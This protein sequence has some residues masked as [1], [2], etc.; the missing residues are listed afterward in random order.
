MYFVGNSGD[1]YRYL[2]FDNDN[3]PEMYLNN[4][5]GTLVGVYCRSGVEWADKTTDNIFMCGGVLVESNASI[6]GVEAIVHDPYIS[7]SNESS[8]YKRYILNGTSASAS[9]VF[10]LNFANHLASI[11]PDDGAPSEYSSV[12]DVDLENVFESGEVY[13]TMSCISTSSMCSSGLQLVIHAN[14][15]DPVLISLSNLTADTGDYLLLY[16][17]NAYFTQSFRD[18]LCTPSRTGP[19][20]TGCLQVEGGTSLWKSVPDCNHSDAQNQW[21]DG[22]F[23]CHNSSSSEVVL[24]GLSED[25][26]VV[27]SDSMNPAKHIVLESDFIPDH[28]VTFSTVSVSNI[29]ETGAQ[30]SFN[31]SIPSWGCVYVTSGYSG[32]YFC[33]NTSYWS[34]NHEVSVSGLTTGRTYTYYA[35]SRYPVPACMGEVEGYGYPATSGGVTYVTLSNSSQGTFSTA[36]SAFKGN[37]SITIT[38]PSG[39]LI[40]GTNARVYAGFDSAYNDG[41]ET[42]P[43]IAVFLRG[44]DFY[45]KTFPLYNITYTYNYTAG[46]LYV[47]IGINR[48]SGGEYDILLYHNASAEAVQNSTNQSYVKYWNGT[49]WTLPSE[50]NP[51]NGAVT[52]SVDGYA[53]EALVN[54]SSGVELFIKNASRVRLNLYSYQVSPTVTWM[55]MGTRYLKNGTKRDFGILRDLGTNFTTTMHNFALPVTFQMDARALEYNTTAQQPSYTLA[56]GPFY[57][58]TPGTYSFYYQRGISP[59]LL[60]ALNPPVE[61]VYW[62]MNL[63]SYPAGASGATWVN[64]GTNPTVQSTWMQ[65]YYYYTNTTVLN[66]STLQIF[67][68]NGSAWTNITGNVD[69]NILYSNLTNFSVILTGGSIIS[70]NTT[71][72]YNPPSSGTSVTAVVSAPGYEITLTLALFT[73]AVLF[74]TVTNINR[75]RG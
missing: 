72:T 28:A 58:D 60:S 5:N 24:T 65:N 35:Q 21:Y 6:S 32:G 13:A 7:V 36:A 64:I 27:V 15:T 75:R 31:T 53:A 29:S 62:L 47:D 63:T 43:G 45:N 66:A 30:F 26:Q 39:D 69:G 46:K 11:N 56:Y 8:M 52:F 12:N 38:P 74:V 40:Y 9:A 67:H 57:V 70:S 48:S 73:A 3:N 2:D 25:E 10:Y 54:D 51:N 42:S 17:S 49:A 1:S 71:V 61:G 22:V 59:T 37:F 44:R 23:V 34:N 41:L 33:D 16:N 19:S 55:N 4:I 20:S 18:V 68:Y 50:Y 14:T